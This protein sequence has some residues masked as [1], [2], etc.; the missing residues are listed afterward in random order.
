MPLVV[1]PCCTSQP[2]LP[3]RARPRGATPACERAR[4]MAPARPARPVRCRAGPG[5]PAL[6]RPCGQV[7]GVRLAAP[8]RRLTYA[9]AM[10]RYGCD[11]PDLRYGL[12]HTDVSAA[13]RGCSFRRGARRPRGRMGPVERGRLVGLGVGTLVARS[14]ECMRRAGAQCASRPGVR[15]A[16]ETARGR[17]RTP[18]SQ[19]GAA[20]Q[21]VRGAAGCLPMR[22]RPAAS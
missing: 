6:A 9:D 14:S 5:R 13:V 1:R 21:S 4:C 18:A 22:W 17:W 7:A 20:S 8:F 19:P 15:P 16:C 11:K 10:E 2:M 12:E 3:P